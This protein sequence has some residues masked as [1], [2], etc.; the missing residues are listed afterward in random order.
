[1]MIP[2]LVL[3]ELDEQTLQTTLTYVDRLERSKEMRKV[4]NDDH[5]PLKNLGVPELQRLNPKHLGILLLFLLHTA[6]FPDKLQNIP[7]IANPILKSD[8]HLASL[9]K[10]RF[11]TSMSHST[12]RRSRGC[13]GCPFNCI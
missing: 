10:L 13:S 9:R 2:L 7:G 6:T 12:R 8:L 11:S 3:E 5:E 4:F 1:M